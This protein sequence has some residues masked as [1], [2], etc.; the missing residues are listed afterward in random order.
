MSRAIPKS[1]ILATRPGPLQVRRQFRAAMSLEEQKKTL[2]GYVAHMH[3]LMLLEIFNHELQED[4]VRIA[5]SHLTHSRTLY[6][7]LIAEILC[8][9]NAGAA[10]PIV[11]SSL[12]IQTLCL[13]YWQVIDCFISSPTVLYICENSLSLN[14]T[15][16]QGEYWCLQSSAQ[17]FF[18]HLHL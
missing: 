6:T 9:F 16:R 12:N 2:S 3:G 4:Q 10:W 1:P 11:N 7:V 8:G 13:G 14:Y 5:F 15:A 18:I 17:K